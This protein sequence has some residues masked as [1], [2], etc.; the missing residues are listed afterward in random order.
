VTKSAEDLHKSLY[1]EEVELVNKHNEEY[2]Q[3]KHTYWKGINQFSDMTEAE[4]KASFGLIIPDNVEELRA[5]APKKVIQTTAPSSIDWREKGAVQRVKDQHHPNWCGSCWAHAAT[6]ALEGRHFIKD[7]G[8][9]PDLGEQQLVSCAGSKYDCNGCN[10]GWYNGAWDY[11][12]DQGSNGIDTFTSYPYTGLDSACDTQKTSDNKD[13]GSICSGPGY[14][15]TNEAAVMEAVGNDGP[16]A[17]AVNCMPWINYSGGIFD[18]SSCNDSPTH[19]VTI[20]GYNDEEKY[21]IIKNSWAESWG[22]SG[23]I[24]MR[25]DSSLPY[26]MCGLAHYAMYPLY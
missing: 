24:R 3:G 10:G 17:I 23:Y 9:L 18:D 21:W 11:I 1:L 12:H 7:G 6:A 13:V 19:A 20:I 5:A 14:C 16:V 2:D 4:K 8:A 26:G 15:E 25:K 22:E